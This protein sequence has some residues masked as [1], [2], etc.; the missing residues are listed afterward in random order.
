M[1]ALLVAYGRTED[2]PAMDSSTNNLTR[3]N[4][5]RLDGIL[6]PLEYYYSDGTNYYESR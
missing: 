1:N 2:I 5:A 3:I 6:N 4:L